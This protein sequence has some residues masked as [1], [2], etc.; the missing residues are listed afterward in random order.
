MR[1]GMSHRGARAALFGDR[2][3]SGYG[4]GPGSGRTVFDDATAQTIEADN[5]QMT[6]ELAEKVA[7]LKQV[8]VVG[9]VVGGRWSVRCVGGGY[10]GAVCIGVSQYGTAHIHTQT[11]AEAA[12]G[13]RRVLCAV[14]VPW[15]RKRGVL[16]A[17]VCVCVCVGP[18]VCVLVYRSHNLCIQK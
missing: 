3:R 12:A 16:T 13:L 8:R 9:W 4:A 5:N 17:C 18:Y 1:P 11:A 15:T 7:A 6:E 10:I 14:S 2:E